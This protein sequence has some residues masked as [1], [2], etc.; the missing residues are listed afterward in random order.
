MQRVQRMSLSKL[1]FIALFFCF[2]TYICVPRA[3]AALTRTNLVNTLSSSVATT[4]TS[5][6]T[7]SD[8]SLLVVFVGGVQDGEGDPTADTLVTGGGL[9][10]TK[11]LT[12]WQ[13]DQNY[14]GWGT[15]INA[16]TAE[17]TSGSS[18]TVSGGTSDT[19]DGVWV[20]VTEFT[21]YDTS[22]PIGASAT[23]PRSYTQGPL[24]F[25]LSASPASDSYVIAG[26]TLNNWQDSSG[27][28]TTPGTGWTQLWEGDNRTARETWGHVQDRTASTS[29]I[30]LWNEVDAI[31][32]T[33]PPNSGSAVAAAIEI[34]AAAAPPAESTG[35]VIRL[36]GVRLQGVRLQ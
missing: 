8:N 5:S 30:V 12:L 27:S 2:F 26:V 13:E 18:M 15:W 1:I 24:S 23:Q 22:S 36:Q 31:P 14:D 7:P 16:W 20:S 19:Q 17:V 6:F 21:G 29:D 11:R 32:G 33:P 10:W 3:E 34:K 28:A 4:T 25:T 9:T 35:R